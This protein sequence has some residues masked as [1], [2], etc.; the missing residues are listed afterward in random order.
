MSRIL[1]RHFHRQFWN[2]NDD[3]RSSKWFENHLHCKTVLWDCLLSTK[4][5]HN[6]NCSFEQRPF[7]HVLF[8]LAEKY[9]LLVRFHTRLEI[10]LKFDWNIMKSF[11]FATCVKKKSETMDYPQITHKVCSHNICLLTWSV[12]ATADPQDHGRLPRAF[13]VR[14]FFR[15]FK[16]V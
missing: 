9:F 12:L 10:L 8:I 7:V 5:S 2:A 16:K 4:Y 1:P 15:I 14:I 6:V 11:S 3:W 13:V